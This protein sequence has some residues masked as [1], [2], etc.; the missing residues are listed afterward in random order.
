MHMAGYTMYTPC[1][2][3]LSAPRCRLIRE[4]FVGRVVGK[5]VLLL[6]EG[7]KRSKRSKR[8]RF[9]DFLHGSDEEF[10]SLPIRVRGRIPIASFCFVRT[11]QNSKREETYF[12]QHAALHLSSSRQ[13]CSQ[14]LGSLPFC[15]F[16]LS[17]PATCY[18]PQDISGYLRISQESMSG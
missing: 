1:T 9:R 18:T 13:R 15:R 8:S 7:S 3:W 14:V 5:S 2:C 16:H 17:W 4:P 12:P 10:A 6:P 11:S